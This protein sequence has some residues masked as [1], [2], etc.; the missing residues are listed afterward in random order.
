MFTSSSL[1][2]ILAHFRRDIKI[3]EEGIVIPVNDF[4]PPA[5]P[6]RGTLE[7][8]PV[9]F[10]F[11]A[12]LKEAERKLPAFPIQRCGGEEE[13]FWCEAKSESTDPKAEYCI[14]RKLS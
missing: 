3:Y 9:H 8:A 12:R 5:P 1:Y 2:I 10:P 7:S 13:R 14:R 4:T 6:P 11:F